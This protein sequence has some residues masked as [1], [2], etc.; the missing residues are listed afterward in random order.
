MRKAF[1]LSVCLAGAI[2]ALPMV[3]SAQL[4]TSDY[5]NEVRIHDP[6]L[7]AFPSSVFVPS[8]SGGLLSPTGLTFGRDFNLYVASQ[9]TGEV[10][11]YEGRT[12]AFLGTF[13]PSG[14]GGLFSPKDL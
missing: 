3:C 14:S 6:L 5:N 2:L 1:C 7:G 4:L 11:L 13:V 10:L 12:A 8:G 9:S